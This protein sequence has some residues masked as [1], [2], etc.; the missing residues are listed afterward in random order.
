MVTQAR[1]GA[2]RQKIIDAAVDLFTDKGYAETGLN[3][4][5]QAADVTTGAFYYHFASKEELATAVNE[6]GWP[7]AWDVVSRHL[8]PD[9]PGLESVIA[10]TFAVTDLLK[11]DKSVW[12]SNHLNQSLGL[13]NEE[14]RKT[15]AH[16]AQSFI[17][18]I[19]GSIRPSDLR[20]GIDREDVGSQV[21]MMLH[22]CHLLSDA[23]G[24][25]VS[26]RLVTSWRTLLRSV[27]SE[28]SLPHFE[29]VIARREPA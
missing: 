5:C 16:R 22:G 1:A 10:M 4:L 9:N 29:Q 19:A 14:G 13:L 27:A 2:T 25:D 26:A 12:V 18:G 3:D 20:E 21:W 24:D 6:Q 8:N 15:F 17:N 28:D 23:F 11:R 7:K